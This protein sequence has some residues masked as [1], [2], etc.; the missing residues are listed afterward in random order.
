MLT[1]CR[2]GLLKEGFQGK[3]HMVHSMEEVEIKEPL[4]VPK[5]PEQVEMWI[6]IPIHQ[7]AR[8]KLQSTLKTWE[9]NL[10]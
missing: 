4:Q 10:T 1:L 5:A 3:I 9:E 7:L 2:L 8:K 6:Q